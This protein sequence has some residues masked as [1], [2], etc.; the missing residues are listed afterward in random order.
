MQTDHNNDTVT[1]F[2]ARLARE[3]VYRTEPHDAPQSSTRSSRRSAQ[4]YTR[5]LATALRLAPRNA[6]TRKPM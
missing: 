4:L 5:Y 6:R 1:D 2:L 3:Q